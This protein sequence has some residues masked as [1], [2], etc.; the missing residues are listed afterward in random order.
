MGYVGTASGN[1]SNETVHVEPIYFSL[2]RRSQHLRIPVD[3]VSSSMD[4]PSTHLRAG[5][6]L[7]T[8]AKPW[9]LSASI[10]N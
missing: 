9:S 1:P 8:G 6:P 5:G 4:A 7:H 2:E 10:L 3:N